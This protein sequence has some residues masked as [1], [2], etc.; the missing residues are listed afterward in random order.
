MLVSSVCEELGSLRR[1]GNGGG[2]EI[3]GT[4]EGSKGDSSSIEF[5]AMRGTLFRRNEMFPCHSRSPLTAES[6]DGP[7]WPP[8]LT[9]QTSYSIR[10]PRAFVRI[11]SSS[12]R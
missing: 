1:G 5:R 8:H 11:T 6:D 7:R 3:V 10:K 4:D 2:L 9:P 12:N